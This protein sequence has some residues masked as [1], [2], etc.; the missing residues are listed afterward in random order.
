MTDTWNQWEGRVVDGQFTLGRY[1]GGSDH[2]AVYICE[3][4]QPEPRR[5]AIK[6]V[7]ESP[8]EDLQLDRWAMAARLAH[9][10]LL[11]V[12][13]SGTCRLDDKEL[14]YVVTELAE[15]NLG[16]ILP[17]RAL[18]PEETRAFLNPVLEALSYLHEKEL[19][20]TAI[21]P[22]NILA[23][24]D[25]IK[26]SCDRICPASAPLIQ[27]GAKDAHDAPEVAAG[28][29]TP[30][31]DL[32]SLGATLVQTLTQHEPEAEISQT[33][34]VQP[35]VQ[36]PEGLPQPFQ[37]IVAHTLVRQPGGRWNVT[38]LKSELDPSAVRTMAAKASAAP[39]S[40]VIAVAP[41]REAAPAPTKPAPRMAPANS[42]RAI[43]PR[44]VS[45]LWYIIPGLGLTAVLVAWVSIN[46]STP[47]AA[48]DTT[49]AVTA[50]L[51][52]PAKS[53]PSK[54]PAFGEHKA[55]AD[56]PSRRPGRTA[57]APATPAPEPKPARLSS[58][59]EPT[60]KTST[61]TH[62]GGQVLDQVMPEVT[63]KALD[64]IHGTVRVA[65][66][67]RVNPDG[68]VASAELDSS[69]PSKYFA[70]KS[71]EAAQKWEFV[72]PEADGRSVPSEWLVRFEFKPN[73]TK[74]YPKQVSP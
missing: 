2:S 62:T 47:H 29:A 43:A 17:Q 60:S 50:S 35:P 11:A 28:T 21:K 27:R 41:K 20:H 52:T 42:P 8:Q 14:L 71:V 58:K 74:A 10:N 24:G 3:I 69:G 54:T 46:R 70:D 55:R 38:D 32:W 13:N 1:L 67:I 30:A 5:A 61:A 63:Q 19:V 64:T 53:D 57:D 44:R 31:S 9:P 23:I 12:L 37:T 26:L 48:Q 36:I 34:K 45:P 65:V 39:Y 59:V 7:A 51:D 56:K 68:S 15:E 66:R 49:A 4:S 40:P 16:E 22:S 33:G 73:S 6:F 18:T 25:Q 72:S